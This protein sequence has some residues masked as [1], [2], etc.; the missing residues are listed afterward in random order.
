LTNRQ[1][2][3]LPITNFDIPYVSDSGYIGEQPLIVQG[4]NVLVHH[5]GR[6]SSRHTLATLGTTTGTTKRIDR[7][8]EFQDSFGY[9]FLLAS[10]YNSA[11]G[12]WELL[13]STGAFPNAF[14]VAGTHRSLDKSTAPHVLTIHRHKAYVKSFTDSSD[15]SRLGSL[16]LEGNGSGGILVKPWGLAG[17]ATPA[18]VNMAGSAASANPITV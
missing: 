13:Y 18:A 9:F 14:A 16:V 11:T 12:Y 10:A 5:T 1:L 4:T 7:L 8:W 3:G 17:P 6:I 15:T 2:D